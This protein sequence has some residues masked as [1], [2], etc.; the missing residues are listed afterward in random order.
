MLRQVADVSRL[1]KYRPDDRLGLGLHWA[2][3]HLPRSPMPSNPDD[4]PGRPIN[5]Y[6]FHKPRL[7]LYEAR[8]NAPKPDTK[9]SVRSLISPLHEI[10]TEHVL[11][12]LKM[13][14]ESGK[15]PPSESQDEIS[16]LAVCGSSRSAV[17]G[18]HG[19]LVCS[20]LQ[21]CAFLLDMWINT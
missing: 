8:S 13:S 10:R 17:R 15:L 4:R 20:T 12:V 19:G 11:I 16:S 6:K 9:R 1:Y 14:Q 5:L 2:C 18:P 21:V 3:I 7:H